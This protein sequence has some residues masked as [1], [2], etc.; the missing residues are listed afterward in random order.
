MA[1]PLL[2]SLMAQSLFNLESSNSRSSQFSS[3]MLLQP[4]R[5]LF[6]TPEASHSG[7]EKHI[8]FTTKNSACALIISL[9]RQSTCVGYMPHFTKTQLNSCS[10]TLGWPRAETQPCFHFTLPPTHP[11]LA[12]SF[13]KVMAGQCFLQ[14]LTCHI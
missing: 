5:E 11:E 7:G 13:H 2:S 1:A 6:R 3:H 12:A 9:S 8:L 14:V 10:K 4:W